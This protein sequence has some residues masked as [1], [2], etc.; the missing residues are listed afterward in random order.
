[1]T[2]LLSLANELLKWIQNQRLKWK[3]NQIILTQDFTQICGPSQVWSFKKILILFLFLQK[4]FYSLSRKTVNAR[5]NFWNV[6]CF[7]T[8]QMRDETAKD[9]RQTAEWI[10]HDLT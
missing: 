4:L 5:E 6:Y 3:D 1:M 9:N 7:A 10:N 2:Q 8:N